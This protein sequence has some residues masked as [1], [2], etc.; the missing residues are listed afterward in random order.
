MFIDYPSS[1]EMTGFPT[2]YERRQNRSLSFA[3]Q[4]LRTEEMARFLPLNPDLPNLQL[5]DRE[6]YIVNFAHGEKYKNSAIPNCQRMLND[7]AKLNKPCQRQRSGEWRVWMA[8]LEE[9]LKRRR[10]DRRRDT[11]PGGDQDTH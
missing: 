10:E 4:C 3:K 2:L 6:Q 7:N 9:R 5:R 11:G 1:C 8:G